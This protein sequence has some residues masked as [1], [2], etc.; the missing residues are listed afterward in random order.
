MPLVIQTYLIFLLHILFAS[1]VLAAPDI[2]GLLT[3]DRGGLA[4]GGSDYAKPEVETQFMG[5]WI[6]DNPNAGVAAM[7]LQLMPNDKVVWFDTTSLGPSGLKLP[8]GVLCPSNPDTKNEPDCYA[9]AIAY[10]WKTT[11]YRTLTVCSYVLSIFSTQHWFTS[12]GR[13]I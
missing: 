11:K 4:D 3:Q 6:I 7:Q 10:D 5:N 9:H 8:E 2:V 12:R 1:S 13:P